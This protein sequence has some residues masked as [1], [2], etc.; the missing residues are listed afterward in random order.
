MNIFNSKQ[1]IHLSP[2]FAFRQKHE[3]GTVKLENDSFKLPFEFSRVADKGAPGSYSH[4]FSDGVL[5]ETLRFSGNNIIYIETTLSE[6]AYVDFRT[7]V[8][9]HFSITRSGTWDELPRF[10]NGSIDW[11]RLCLFVKESVTRSF[12]HGPVHVN[13]DISG[14]GLNIY[15]I[16]GG[17]HVY[18]HFS[19]DGSWYVDAYD[20]RSDITCELVSVV[21]RIARSS[22][23][24]I[25]LSQYHS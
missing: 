19:T 9:A 18:L 14:T 24:R 13:I 22:S 1:T 3:I 17:N 10:E 11:K 5:V 4:T 23:L 25:L 15:R 20:Q 21:E 2:F 7:H 12:K 8:F 16:I 6:S